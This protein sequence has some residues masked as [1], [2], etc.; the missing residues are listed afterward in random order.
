MNIERET[1][2]AN[3]SLPCDECGVLHRVNYIIQ[4]DHAKQHADDYNI[5]ICPKC[6]NRLEKLIVRAKNDLHKRQTE[7]LKETENVEPH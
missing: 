4:G 5:T 3:E 2:P 1:G 6:F 7:T